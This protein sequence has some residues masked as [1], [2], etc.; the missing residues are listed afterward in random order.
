MAKGDIANRRRKQIIDGL[1]ECLATKGHEH[2][3][4]RDIARAAHVSYG[5]LHYYFRDKKEIMLALVEDFVRQHEEMFEGSVGS[6][7]SSWDRLRMLVSIS[8]DELIF[9]K[10]TAQV[11]LNLYQLGCTDEEV[12]KALCNSYAHFRQ[13]VRKVIEYGISRGEFAKVNPEEAALMAV[14][15]VEGLYLQLTVDPSV[16]DKNKAERLLYE[17]FKRQLVPIRDHL[18]KKTMRTSDGARDDRPSMRMH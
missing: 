12:R 15:V 5:A 4:I 11:F 16:C 2:V 9:D 1:Y 10:R 3:T 6:A 17:S 7:S 18:E 8:T 13:E 14:G